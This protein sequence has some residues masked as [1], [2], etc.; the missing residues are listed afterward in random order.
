MLGIFLID[1][2]QHVVDIKSFN[3]L[4]KEI[5]KFKSLNRDRV[6]K[7]RDLIGLQD[8]KERMILL[9]LYD[10]DHWA[11][12]ILEKDWNT[13]FKRIDVAGDFNVKEIILDDNRLK[14]V[15]KTFMEKGELKIK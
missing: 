14:D 10:R 11:L 15:L 7:S 8:E 4:W 9:A 3:D 12:E 2:R 13:D 1:D 5:L 6:E